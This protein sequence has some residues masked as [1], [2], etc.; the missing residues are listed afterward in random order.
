MMLLL[1]EYYMK[2]ARRTFYLHRDFKSIRGIY[3]RRVNEIT[4][5][6]N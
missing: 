2:A 6:I 3:S 1:S 4:I 5:W